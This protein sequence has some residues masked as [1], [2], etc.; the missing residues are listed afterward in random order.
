MV[1]GNMHATE[2]TG[3][4]FPSLRARRRT[5]RRP[6]CPGPPFVSFFRAESRAPRAPCA[7]TL[8]GEP[9]S[10]GVYARFAR[11]CGAPPCG[12]RDPF[13]H[14]TLQS[15][16]STDRTGGSLRR[17]SCG[18]HIA[19]PGSTEEVVS[20]WFRREITV[21]L[22]VNDRYRLSIAAP[23]PA[24]VGIVGGVVCAA[25]VTHAQAEPL[26]GLEELALVPTP[27]WGRDDP[28]WR[29]MR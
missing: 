8:R 26:L 3:A 22:I 21:K 12:S 4:I 11:R 18:S 1:V 15:R 29:L 14:S 16:E 7:C 5:R 17:S 28:L 9:S 25:P 13:S 24:A 23:V 19:V 20:G 6:V 10:P 2:L 27:T